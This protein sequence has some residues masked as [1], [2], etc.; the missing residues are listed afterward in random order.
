MTSEWLTPGPTVLAVVALESTDNGIRVEFAVHT[1]HPEDQPLPLLEIE[2]SQCEARAI[3][4]RHVK[5]VDRGQATQI[6]GEA[7][8][9]LEGPGAY[10]LLW[11][12][13]S[14]ECHF[15]RWM[16]SQFGIG[17]EKR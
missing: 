14:S 7:L 6:D 11:A 8:W 3:L 10:W 15:V 12:D 5:L 13:E 9:M 17:T 1:A 4:G 16:K 2:R